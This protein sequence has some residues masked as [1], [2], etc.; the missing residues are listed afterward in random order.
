MGPLGAGFDADSTT[1]TFI[2]I[3]YPDIAVF[4]INMTGTCWTIL[5]TQRGDALS[6]YGHDNIIGVFGE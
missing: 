4:R 6:A 1:D 2:G 3:D 5:N